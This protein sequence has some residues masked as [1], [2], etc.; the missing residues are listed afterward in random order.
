MPERI[1]YADMKTES[2]VRLTCAAVLGGAAVLLA[3]FLRRLGGAL[4]PFLAAALIASLLR[5]ALLR[6]RQRT[7]LPTRLGGTILILFAA[8]LLS[9]GLFALGS[10]LYG[11]AKDVVA[12]L[13]AQLDDGMSP[14]SRF[15]TGSRFSDAGGRLHSLTGWMDTLLREGVTQASAWLASC[16]ADVLMGLPRLLCAAAAS[17]LAL[18]YLFF[19]GERAL[20]PLRS[21]IGEERLTRIGAAAGEMRAALGAWLRAGMLL[22]FLSFAVLLSG[23]LLLGI[24]HAVRWALF[25]SLIDALPVFGVGA[26]LVPWS[27][28][29]FLR[30]DLFR[31]AGLLILF[32]VTAAV[33]Q[34]AQPR[35]M[36]AS[37][38]VHPLYVLIAV[39]AG[40]VLGGAAGLLLA[41][42]VLPVLRVLPD[43]VRPHDPSEKKGGTASHS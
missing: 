38:G 25:S 41:P 4:M 18:F 17:V 5:P 8:A 33:R 7:R 31:G 29:R 9:G 42:L 10:M 12:S 35:I 1:L 32:G 2:M 36:G 14:L 21:L 34:Y 27:I 39:Y 6:L 37:L 16:A 40:L 22:S 24:G 30:G 23:F 20:A 3:P 13:A 11:A 19:D 15:L 26:V 43:V 28:Y